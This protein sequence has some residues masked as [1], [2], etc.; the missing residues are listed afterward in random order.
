MTVLCLG[1]YEEAVIPDF[2]DIR[3]YLSNRT[4]KKAAVREII[5]H[6]GVPESNRPAF[7]RMMK[8]LADRP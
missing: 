4:G 8:N 3:L 5:R 6:F 2:E 7:R 1:S